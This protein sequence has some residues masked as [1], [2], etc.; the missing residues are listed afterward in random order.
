MNQAKMFYISETLTNDILIERR[1]QSQSNFFTF[2]MMTSN[3][4][5]RD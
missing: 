1:T 3:Q 5:G 2:L 4:D